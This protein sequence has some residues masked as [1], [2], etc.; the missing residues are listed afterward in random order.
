METCIK[1]G[2]LAFSFC[3][4]ILERSHL[5]QEVH[6]SMTVLLQK[7][8]YILMNSNHEQ[9]HCLTALLSIQNIRLKTGENVSKY[10]LNAKW[11]VI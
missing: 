6:Y 1:C 8:F 5:G 7:G 4:E 11:S 10:A 3:S 2:P 9:M